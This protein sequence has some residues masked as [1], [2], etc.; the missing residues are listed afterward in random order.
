VPDLKDYYAPVEASVGDDPR[1]GVQ[2]LTAAYKAKYNV[3]PAT[4]YGYPIYSGLELW[5]K[6]VTEAGTTDAKA[7]VAKMNAFKDEPTTLGPR[8]ETAKYHIQL[9]MPELIEEVQNGAFKVI[10]NWDLAE[11]IPDDVVFMKKK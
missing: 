11:P 7:V 5:A 8:T 1:P 4:M 6:G 10:D 3:V 9:K 2:K